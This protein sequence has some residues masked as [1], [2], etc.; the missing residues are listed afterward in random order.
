MK[1]T[2]WETLGISETSD[3]SAIRKA[4]ASQLKLIDEDPSGASFMALREAFE[5]AREH[6]RDCNVE[7]RTD[8]HEGNDS[9]DPSTDTVA[10]EQQHNPDSLNLLLDNGPEISGLN[11]HAHSAGLQ[12]SFER[13]CNLLEIDNNEHINLEEFDKILVQIVK[14]I[15]ENLDKST[16]DQLENI[17]L[18]IAY[19]LAKSIP[20]SNPILEHFIA[21]FSWHK[22]IENYDKPPVVRFIVERAKLNRSY[23]ELSDPNHELHNAFI[24]LNSPERTRD[25]SYSLRRNTR[26]LLELT[27][28]KFP[29]I[30]RSFNRDRVGEW[31]RILGIISYD[32]ENEVK[33][34]Y[35][36]YQSKNKTANAIWITVI[37]ILSLF[38][39]IFTDSENE[40]LNQ[41]QEKYILE[42]SDLDSEKM[43]RNIF[44]PNISMSKIKEVNPQLHNLIITNESISEQKGKSQQYFHESMRELFLYRY[45]DAVRKATPE[46]LRNFWNLQADKTQLLLAKPD[47]CFRFIKGTF[48]DIEIPKKIRDVET[49]QMEL[50]LLNYNPPAEPTKRPEEFWIPAEVVERMVTK[51]GISE[52]ELSK[53]FKGEASETST[54]RSQIAFYRSLAESRSK[55][56]LKIM[57]LY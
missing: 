31:E 20:Y 23:A 53:F 50:V 21:Y 26:S 46:N 1:R 56:A 44:G 14:E 33:S 15:T 37:S 2:I 24:E 10:N 13:F 45:R 12:N 47:E 32:E 17:E 9:Y 34:N 40:R 16:A 19:S 7:G 52:S 51:Y 3:V 38:A 36:S 35:T 11:T 29:D 49:R 54:C 57:R 43:V 22:D 27:Y 48:Y 25:I 42:N 30:Y 6:A 39:L 4:Y 55:E 8:N 28:H 18:P 41:E 5:Q